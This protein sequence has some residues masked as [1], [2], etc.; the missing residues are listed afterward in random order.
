MYLIKQGPKSLRSNEFDH[1]LTRPMVTTAAAIEHTPPAL[2]TAER[3]RRCTYGPTCYRRASSHCAQFSHPGDPDWR[4]PTCTSSSAAEAS[5]AAMPA[6][7]SAKRKAE[8]AAAAPGAVVWAK[9]KGFPAWPA[10]VESVEAKASGAKA[11]VVFFGTGDQASVAFADVTPFADGAKLRAKSKAKKFV[12]AVAEAEQA[13]GLSLGKRH[14]PA[15]SPPAE[16]VRSPAGGATG[17]DDDDGEEEI[18]C[19]ACGSDGDDAKMVLCDGCPRGYHIYCLSPKLRRVPKGDWHC[20]TCNPPEQE[21]PA[22]AMEAEPAQAT[23]QAE[24]SGV[25]AYG[26]STSSPHHRSISGDIC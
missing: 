8:P 7:S 2:A 9:L 14:K 26:G 6:A 5:A 1:D 12:Q 15:A 20:P 10:Q 23:Q 24:E 4:E 13:A 19:Q 17:G 16:K 18:A 22:Q 21:E 25:S 11:T 3:R